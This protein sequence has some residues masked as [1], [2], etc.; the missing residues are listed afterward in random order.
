MVEFIKSQS[1]FNTDDLPKMIKVAGVAK[2]VRVTHDGTCGFRC[3]AEQ[4]GV[5]LEN[6]VQRFINLKS[7][8]ALSNQTV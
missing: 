6:M 5:A 8:K 7:E 3:I 2:F 4:I 1:F